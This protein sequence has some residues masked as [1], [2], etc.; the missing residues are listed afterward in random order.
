M[1]Q[2]E[3]RRLLYGDDAEAGLGEDGAVNEDG[4]SPLRFQFYFIFLFINII[5]LLS[6]LFNFNFSQ[7]K[8]PK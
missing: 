6:L 5:L 3:K 7:E 4:M 2:V 1:L 8:S